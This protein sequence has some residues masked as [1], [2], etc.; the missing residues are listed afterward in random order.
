MTESAGGDPSEAPRR[1]D[2]RLGGFDGLPSG[3]G[4]RT[5]DR[6]AQPDRSIETCW[7][8][9]SQDSA[10]NTSGRDP[11]N[12]VALDHEAFVARVLRGPFAAKQAPEAPPQRPRIRHQRPREAATNSAGQDEGSLESPELL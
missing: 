6:A 2:S 7:S 1:I 5:S 9:L 10:F 4:H 11:V 12:V 8:S 3:Q